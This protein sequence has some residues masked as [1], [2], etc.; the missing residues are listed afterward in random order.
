MISRGSI[1]NWQ[2]SEK[3]IA[4]FLHSLVAST[5]LHVAFCDKIPLYIKYTRWNGRSSSLWPRNSPSR[6]TRPSARRPNGCCYYDP[7]SALHFPLDVIIRTTCLN[8]RFPFFCYLSSH[9]YM[10]FLLPSSSFLPS[11][12]SPISLFRH[13]HHIRLYCYT[14]GFR[15]L[16][17][18][19]LNSPARHTS[20]VSIIKSV[21][22]HSCRHALLFSSAMVSWS[23]NRYFTFC[24]KTNATLCFIKNSYSKC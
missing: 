6:L 17:M 22:F 19:M 16:A 14:C 8:V 20:G 5:T 23:I 2:S 24:K 21:I 18:V 4:S 13:G 9:I 1:K 3:T 12:P 11:H 7:Q 10:S 15:W